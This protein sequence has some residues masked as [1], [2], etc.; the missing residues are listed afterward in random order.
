LYSAQSIIR[1]PTMHTHRLFACVFLLALTACAPAVVAT[2][3]PSPAATVAPTQ[4]AAATPAPI[5]PAGHDL[6]PGDQVDPH[7]QARLR[8]GYFAAGGPNVHLIV[9]PPPATTP[10]QPQVN[11]PADYIAGYLF[12]PPA[13][14]NV[15]V[16]PTGQGLSQ[17]LAGPLDVALAAGH[18]YTLA[19]MG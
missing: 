8:L 16:V 13:T 3:A 4:P 19:V 1:R 7:T 10:D 5:A 14:Y 11:I 15:A 6:I 2:P 9:N 18:R 12:L 17:A